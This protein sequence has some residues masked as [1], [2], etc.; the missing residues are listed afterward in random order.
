LSDEAEPGKV[1]V[2]PKEVLRVGLLDSNENTV[3]QC[4]RALG[5]PPRLSDAKLYRL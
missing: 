2:G 1:C 4:G 3:A 5:I